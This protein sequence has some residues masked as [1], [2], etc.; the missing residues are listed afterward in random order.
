MRALVADV[1]SVFPS[2]CVTAAF[3]GASLASV[4]WLD[5]LDLIGVDAF[6]SLSKTPYPLGQAAPV[7]ELTA[8]WAQ[9]LQ[10]MAGASAA[11]NRSVLVAATGATS[12]PNCHL[13]PWGTGAPGKPDGNDQGDDSA[14]PLRGGGEFEGVGDGLGNVTAVG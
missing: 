13:L 3:T 6:W 9:A 2:G 1:R 11:A 10:V 8:G 5:E 14:W 7:A 4:A 12:R